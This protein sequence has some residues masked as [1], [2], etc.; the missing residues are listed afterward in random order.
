MDR[1]GDKMV[2]LLRIERGQA[3]EEELA[4][5]AVTLFSVVSRRRDG[6]QNADQGRPVGP[7][8]RRRWDR[9]YRAPH[10]WR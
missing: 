1:A 8:D 4:A 7:W 9:T 6:E 2:A 3:T 10:S 5:V